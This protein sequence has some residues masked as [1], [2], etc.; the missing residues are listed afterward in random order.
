MKK[1]PPRYWMFIALLIFNFSCQKDSG[2]LEH[3]YSSPNKENT[4]NSNPADI[5]VIDGHIKTLEQINNL[6]ELSPEEIRIVNSL[7]GNWNLKTIQRAEFSFSKLKGYL[8]KNQIDPDLSALVYNN[9]GKIFKVFFKRELLSHSIEKIEKVTMSSTD[10]SEYMSFT[11]S[12]DKF[13]SHL[14]ASRELPFKSIMSSEE[15]SSI[16]QQLAAG[17]GGCERL[18]F[19]DCIQCAVSECMSDW[20]CA[21]MCGLAAEL[22]I[23]TWT[24]TC[25]LAQI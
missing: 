3:P 2:S 14:K 11:L 19:G 22:C 25:S 7:G 15:M 21:I 16:K 8:I 6:D 13:L 5:K 23:G 4:L 10:G 9:G 24:I 12:N 18:P 1:F 20:Q 17:S